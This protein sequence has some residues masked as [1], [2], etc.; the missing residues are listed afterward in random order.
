M[1]QKIAKLYRIPL[2]L[3]ITLFIIVVALRVEKDPITISLIFTGCILGTFFLDLDYI[4]HAYF[5]E[6]ESSFS[7]MML[8]YIKHKDVTGLFNY[9]YQHRYDLPDRTLNSGL[10]QIVLGGASIITVASSA[11]LIVKGIVVSAFLNS[12]YRF[13]DA[14]M[15]NFTNKWFWNLKLDTANKYV[16]YGYTLA[17]LATL[18]YSIYTF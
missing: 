7:Q 18:V 1:S 3:S 14:H 4:I 12:I 8:G 15:N 17:L 10:F 9:I 6:P 16:M 2:L 5:I 13:S 11:S